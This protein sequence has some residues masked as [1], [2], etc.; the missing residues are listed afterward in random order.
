MRAAKQR[1][2][3][4]AA[5]HESGG[6]SNADDQH[7]AAEHDAADRNAPFPAGFAGQ[8]IRHEHAGPQAS[9]KRAV[10]T[11]SIPHGTTMAGLVANRL[12]NARYLDLKFATRGCKNKGERRSPVALRAGS[13][14]DRAKY[15][16]KCGHRYFCG[17]DV[18][19]LKRRS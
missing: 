16:E 15:I 2:L 12:C 17:C 11:T 8:M 14:R 4:E 19:H 5:D 18:S 9:M 3:A 10:G 7:H 13:N 1:P 6:N